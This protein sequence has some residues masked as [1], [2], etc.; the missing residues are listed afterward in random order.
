MVNCSCESD[1]INLPDV[2]KLTNKQHS[3]LQIVF[4]LTYYGIK[5]IF[6]N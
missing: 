6:A 2:S 3:I 5:L 4:T 1:H